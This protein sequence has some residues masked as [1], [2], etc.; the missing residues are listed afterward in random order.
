[1]TILQ[2][3]V[4]L[5]FVGFFILMFSLMGTGSGLPW[6]GGPKIRQRSAPELKARKRNHKRDGDGGN[7]DGGDDG[8]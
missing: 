4:F 8:D 5:I 3:L 6:S 2:F 7:E 1:M